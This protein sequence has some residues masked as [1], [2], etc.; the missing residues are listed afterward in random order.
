MG[1]HD[2]SKSSRTELERLV[3]GYYRDVLHPAALSPPTDI[4]DRAEFF[5]YWSEIRARSNNPKDKLGYERI[6]NTADS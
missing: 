4:E 3:T 5:D 2:L 1:R 6:Q